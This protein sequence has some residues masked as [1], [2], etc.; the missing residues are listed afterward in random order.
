MIFETA[1][2]QFRPVIITLENRDDFDKLCTILTQVAENRINHA[3]QVIEAAQW[4][5]KR[6]SKIE[7]EQP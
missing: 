3:P 5:M 7:Q 6:L 1:E 4:M 2:A